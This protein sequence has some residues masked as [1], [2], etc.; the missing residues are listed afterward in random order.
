MLVDLRGQTGMRERSLPLEPGGKSTRSTLER[1]R[2]WLLSFPRSQSLPLS[3]VSPRRVISCHLSSPGP[4]G[5]FHS[6]L[7]ILNHQRAETIDIHPYW[8]ALSFEEISLV[9]ERLHDRQRE[10]LLV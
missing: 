2:E 8:E 5:H 4:R 3:G 6:L 9:G 10:Q 1:G 7:L